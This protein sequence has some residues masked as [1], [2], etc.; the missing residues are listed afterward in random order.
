[1]TLRHLRGTQVNDCFTWHAGVRDVQVALEVLV[2]RVGHVERRVGHPHGACASPAA[3]LVQVRD[4]VTRAADEPE[5][6]LDAR[7]DRHATVQ[8]RCHQDR[9]VPGADGMQLVIVA[10][11]LAAARRRYNRPINNNTYALFLRKKSQPHKTPP[12]RFPPYYWHCLHSIQN[13][14]YETVWC[15]SI[16]MSVSAWAHSSKPGN[17]TTGPLTFYAITVV[18]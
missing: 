4:D 14:V 1:M 16:H 7:T 2:A 9:A 12:F 11:L 10:V 8:R 6:G 13:R 15:P 3:A 18:Q 5:V 17:R